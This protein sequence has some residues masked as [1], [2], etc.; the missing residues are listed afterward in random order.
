MR[1]MLRWSTCVAFVL[2][3]TAAD[4]PAAG[5]SILGHYPNRQFYLIDS[6]SQVDCRQVLSGA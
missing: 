3:L 4:I 6:A 2:T 1:A 5:E